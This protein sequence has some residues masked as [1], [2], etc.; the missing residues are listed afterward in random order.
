MQ[1]LDWRALMW[2]TSYWRAHCCRC[3]CW[4]SDVQTFIMPAMMS[5]SSVAQ[6]VIIPMKIAE[7][8]CWVEPDQLSHLNFLKISLAIVFNWWQ[9]LFLS[10]FAIL[11]NIFLEIGCRPPRSSGRCR[12][13]C[14][15][16]VIWSNLLSSILFDFLISS[17]LML[18]CSYCCPSMMLHYLNT[19]VL[20]EDAWATQKW[21]NVH[22]LVLV[23]CMPL[24]HSVVGSD[25]EGCCWD[26]SWELLL[27]M[28]V[29][30]TA[31]SVP[32]ANG[33]RFPGWVV[34]YD[35]VAVADD[36]FSACCWCSP[37]A[38]RCLSTVWS[39]LFF[40]QMSCW[41]WCL[42]LLTTITGNGAA[43]HFIG[44]IW[45][46]LGLFDVGFSYSRQSSL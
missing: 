23:R 17:L 37:C 30:T 8:F 4:P 2:Q 31:G 5:T 42:K 20:F 29:R 18:R 33:S 22:Q 15:T 25:P 10:L 21:Q 9:M 28:F 26:C 3:R 1:W 38:S 11:V 36:C 14:R 39:T 13:Q 45:M 43:P 40:S 16:N 7:K 6:Q 46:E 19:K 32:S 27:E 34:E 41:I 24:R 44:T 35:I 12:W